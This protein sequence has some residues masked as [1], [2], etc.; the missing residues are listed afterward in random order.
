MAFVCFLSIR[1]GVITRDFGG[2]TV[3]STIEAP[4]SERN[5]SEELREEPRASV[6]VEVDSNTE[7]NKQRVVIE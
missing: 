6:V 3:N 4:K 5:S 1:D 2:L 7:Q